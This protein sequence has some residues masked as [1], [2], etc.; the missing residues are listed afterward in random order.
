M[1]YF[2]EDGCRKW[3]VERMG[4]KT[5]RKDEQCP[6][7]GIRRSDVEKL[8]AMFSEL[9]KARKTLAHYRKAV[10]K[11]LRENAHLADGDNCTLIELKRL[12]K[13]K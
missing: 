11:C 9:Q 13:R 2:L 4:P 8:L 1:A 7:C 3:L 12:L 5:K 10:R 6:S